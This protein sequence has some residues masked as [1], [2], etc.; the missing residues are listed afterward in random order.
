MK[1]YISYFWNIRNL[2]RN[3]VPLSTA[4]S[5]PTYF[6]NGL[7]K[8]YQYVDKKGIYN[9]LR[10][11]MLAPGPQ[12]AGLCCGDCAEKKK[13]CAFLKGYRE[14]L[15]KI[16]FEDF[17]KRTEVLCKKVGDFLNVEDPFPVFLVHEAPSNPCSERWALFDWLAEN[18]IQVEEYPIPPKKSHKLKRQY[19][20]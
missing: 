5:D 19:F 18:G 3:A 10:C 14:Q 15:D 2:S 16:N 12:L 4:L 11:E 17:I 13:D 6:H 7:G 1:Y 8:R 9:G 20:F